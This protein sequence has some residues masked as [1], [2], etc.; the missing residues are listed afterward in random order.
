M[1]F[2]LLFPIFLSEKEMP[3]DQIKNFLGTIRQI[4]SSGGRDTDHPKIQTGIQAG[5]TAYGQYGLL[6][7]TVQEI[8]NRNVMRGDLDPDMQALKNMPTENVNDFL[9]QNPDVEEGI[10]TDL[11]DR[12]LTNQ[13]GNEEKAAYSW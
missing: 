7:Y 6:P 1:I 3:N 10:A 4:E 13:G 5:T 12:V 8:A 9:S 2:L 11:A